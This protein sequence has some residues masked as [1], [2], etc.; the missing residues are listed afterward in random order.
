[1]GEMS[2]IKRSHKIT[3]DYYVNGDG[4]VTKRGLLSL[5]LKQLNLL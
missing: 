4:S 1:M 3:S 5:A 2:D